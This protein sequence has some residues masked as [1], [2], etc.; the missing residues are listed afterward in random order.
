MHIGILTS[1]RPKQIDDP[2]LAPRLIQAARAMGHEVT[3]LHEPEIVIAGGIVTHMGAELPKLDVIINR[4][5]FVEEPSL[6]AVT[7]DALV[8]LGFR[9]INHSPLGG[10]AKNKLAQHFILSRAGVA[11]PRWA[12]CRTSDHARAEAAKIGYPI[13]LKVA[14]G[15]HGKGIFY[16]ENVETLS[17]IVE[18]LHIR[19]KNP[20]IVEEFIAEAGRKDLRAFVVGD[21]VIAAM[22]R[23]AII[24]DVRANASL[25]GVGT[26][27]ELTEEEMRMAIEAAK[28]FSLEIAGVD[29]LRS[30][31]GPLVIE[32]NA[33][34]GFEELERASGVDVAG[35]IVDFAVKTVDGL[36]RN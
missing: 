20:I 12:I 35:A 18:Y 24:G 5:G 34:P 8:A 15:T 33:N 13:I 16:A 17:P 14:F 27:V 28:A 25:G 3:M 32:V 9:V 31:R 2:A 26:A 36:N 7:T 6:H 10:I 1:G 19:D 11:M 4:P 23:T 21:Q 22:E 30:K 29:I